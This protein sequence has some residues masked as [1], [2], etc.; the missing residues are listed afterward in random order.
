MATAAAAELDPGAQRPR[1]FS[2]D[3]SGRFDLAEPGAPATWRRSP[4][5]PLVEVGA[6]LAYIDRGEVSRRSLA[7]LRV[8]RALRLAGVVSPLAAGGASARC[9]AGAHYERDSHPWARRFAEG[10]FDGIR[11]GLSHEPG[12]RL[13]GV[14]IFGDAGEQPGFG[15]VEDGPIPEALVEEAVARF[16]FRYAP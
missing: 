16:G 9:S 6:R 15:P 7:S 3:G 5:A 8:P 2:S 13:L 12:L 11:Y 10:G 1:W 4:S 14:A